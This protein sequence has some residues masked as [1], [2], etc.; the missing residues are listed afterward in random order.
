[1]S[2]V[3]KEPDYL[4]HL[5]Y[6]IDMVAELLRAEPELGQLGWRD[7]DPLCN[8]YLEAILSH[9]RPFWHL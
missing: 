9:V 2:K 5:R 3:P 4:R 7:N 1:M 8:A 6:E